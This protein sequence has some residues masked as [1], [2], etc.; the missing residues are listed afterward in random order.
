MKKVSEKKRVSQKERLDRVLVDRGMVPSRQRA[1]GLILAG[2]V[3]VGGSPMV[4]A[5]TLVSSKDPIS[6]L[7]EAN[8]FVSRGGLKLEGALKGFGV[9]PKGKV[10]MDMGASTGG[11]TDCLLSQGVRCVYAVDVGYGQL[12]WSLRNDPRVI[13]LERTHVRDLTRERVSSDMDLITVDVSFISLKKVIPYL[14]KFLKDEGELLVLV[15]P[16][17][18]VGKGAVEKGGVI[19]S[20]R[21]QKNVIE[22]IMQFLEGTGF[23]TGGYVPSVL[24]GNQEFFIYAKKKRENNE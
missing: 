11:F 20:E 3:L 13:V 24:K 8:P 4:K 7:E 12:D 22:D 17:F 15:K 23:K 2:K 16:Q 9:H 19:R 1:Q 5:G 10:A 18:E 21:K 14:I 6:I